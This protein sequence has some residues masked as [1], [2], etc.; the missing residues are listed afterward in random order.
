M[1]ALAGGFLS[2]LAEEIKQVAMAGRFDG[3]SAGLRIQQSQPAMCG[4]EARKNRQR[5]FEGENGALALSETGEGDA[6]VEV[7]E[8][9]EVLEADGDESLGGGFLKL[10]L[11][12]INGGKS[13]M[14]F[15]TVAVD[16]KRALECA[17]GVVD[18]LAAQIGFAEPQMEIG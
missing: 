18:P 2:A 17:L 11:A 6:E 7:S 8:R 16:F 12:E 14:R 4:G 1:S 5:S 9:S 3:V 13:D 10:A 15:G